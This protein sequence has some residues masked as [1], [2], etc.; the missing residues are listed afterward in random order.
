MPGAYQRKDLTPTPNHKPAP[1][2]S[3]IDALIDKY[4]P[5]PT[6]EA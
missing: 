6:G 3:D 2:A 5:E 1:N 4:S